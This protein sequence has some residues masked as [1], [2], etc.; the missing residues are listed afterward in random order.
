MDFFHCILLDTSQIMVFSCNFTL[1]TLNLVQFKN[2]RVFYV[3]SLETKMD[4]IN[5]LE[6]HEFLYYFNRNCG[7]ANTLP[8]L[9]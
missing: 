7:Y 6:L 4:F 2:L 5:F 9:A 1:Y 3:L 8:P